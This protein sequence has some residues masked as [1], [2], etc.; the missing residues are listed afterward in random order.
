MDIKDILNQTPPML[1]AGEQ[2]IIG[3]KSFVTGY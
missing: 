1:L 3:K 2:I